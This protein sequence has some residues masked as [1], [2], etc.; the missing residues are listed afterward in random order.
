MLTLPE[1]PRM[2]MPVPAGQPM[3]LPSEVGSSLFR[4]QGQIQAAHPH[5]QDAYA[6]HWMA[7]RQAGFVP[8]F[9]RITR[10]TL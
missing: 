4:V 1:V 3:R 9:Q 2:Q 10:H 7:L 8:E 6:M 5:I